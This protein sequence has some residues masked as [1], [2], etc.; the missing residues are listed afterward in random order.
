[1]PSGS[2][3]AVLRQVNGFHFPHFPPQLSPTAA[4]AMD[5]RGEGNLAG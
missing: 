2:K 1:M 4:E 3:S 5:A